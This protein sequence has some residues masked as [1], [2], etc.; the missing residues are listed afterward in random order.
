MGDRWG[1]CQRVCV[2]A[3]VCVSV[4]VSAGGGGYGYICIVCFQQL[5]QAP[6]DIQMMEADPKHL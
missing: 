3:C 2:S 6:F 4:C 5:S 1:V